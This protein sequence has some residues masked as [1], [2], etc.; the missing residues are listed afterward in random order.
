MGTWA[1]RLDA[2]PRLG[3]VGEPT[4][5]T[6]APRLSSAYGGPQLLFKRDDLLPVAFGGNKVR[7]L[8]FIVAEALRQDAGTLVAGAGPLS[9]HVRATAGVAA[10]ARLRCVAIYWGSAPARVE[11]NHLLTRILGAEIRFNN[12]FDP[13]SVDFAIHDAAAEIAARGGHPYSIPRGGACALA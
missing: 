10:F 12:N 3:L 8:D 6:F 4:P 9:N 5:L 7:S 2:I 11:G 13:A 1:S